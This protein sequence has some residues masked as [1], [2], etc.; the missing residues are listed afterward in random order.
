MTENRHT[1]TDEPD[2]PGQAAAGLAERVKALETALADIYAVAR[3]EDKDY[4]FVTAAA[5][6][7][8][9]APDPPPVPDDA[10][11]RDLSAAE[12]VAAWRQLLAKGIVP[13]LS[14]YTAHPMFTI[15]CANRICR[16][17][18]PDPLTA[19]SAAWRAFQGGEG[20][21]AWLQR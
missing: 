15:P 18:D 20:R 1:A 6:L 2:A 13:E 5:A 17:M 9:P 16:G 14:P 3:V 7:L 4:H 21:I 8:P 10:E 11:G 12:M 19:F